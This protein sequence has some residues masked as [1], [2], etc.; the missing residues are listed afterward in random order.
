VT[1]LTEP[2]LVVLRG[3]VVVSAESDGYG[4]VEPELGGGQVLFRQ[5]SVESGCRP[6]V[7]EVVDYVLADGSFALEAVG[8]TLVDSR[9]SERL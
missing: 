3:K 4:F 1:S 6:R 7:G 5:D 9:R 8:V 2:L